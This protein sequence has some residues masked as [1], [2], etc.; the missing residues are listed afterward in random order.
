MAIAL[1]TVPLPSK[2]VPRPVT[3]GGNQESAQGGPSTPV[4]R[5]GDRWAVDF[6][7]SIR[8]HAEA[9]LW[10]VDL[11]RAIAEDARM[12]WP[13]P[14]I[15]VGTPGSAVVNGA[16]QNGSV[17]AMRTMT[18]GYVIGKGQGFNLIHNGIRYIHVASA[19]ATVSG[20]GTV[21]LPIWPMLR[22]IPSDGDVCDFEP[23]IEGQLVGGERGVALI[24][25]RAEAVQ[26]S[27]VERQ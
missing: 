10:E 13:Q 26:L 18:P 11:A 15:V 6:T 21:T 5:R 14:G 20:G 27:I 2:A 12:P 17:L 22:V 23:M 1:P 9:L 16:D 7:V 3:F 4:N 19:V 25:A 24:R 8:S